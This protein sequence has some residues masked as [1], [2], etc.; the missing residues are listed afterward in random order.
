M[1]RQEL[2][3]FVKYWRE[4]MIDSQTGQERPP[5]GAEHVDELTGIRGVDY[6][7]QLIPWCKGNSVSVELTTLQTYRK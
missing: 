1:P 7:T 6:K 3:D 4:S 5:G 2:E